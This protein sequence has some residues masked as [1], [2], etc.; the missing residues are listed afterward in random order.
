MPTRHEPRSVVRN[1][2][3]NKAIAVTALSA[4]KLWDQNRLDLAEDDK[5]YEPDWEISEQDLESYVEIAR[6]D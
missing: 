5:L 6:D 3:V 1:R 4:D 2:T